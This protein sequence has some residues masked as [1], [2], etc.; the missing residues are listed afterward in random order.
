MTVSR[1]GEVTIPPIRV[2]RVYG[3]DLEASLEQALRGDPPADALQWLCRAVG[4]SRVI[5]VRA[6]PGGMS[7]AVHRVVLETSAGSR[8]AVVLRRYVLDWVVEEAYVPPNEVDVLT[9]LEHSPVPAPRLIAADPDGTVTGT[10]TVV[11]TYLPGRVVWRPDDRE[12]WLRGLVD[13]LLLVHAEPPD[14][15]RDWFPY[16]PSPGQVPPSWT[17]DVPAWERALEA[18]AGPAPSSERVFLHRDYHPG[19]VLWSGLELTGIVDW[20]SAC[21]G[22]PEVD[23]AH[24]RFNLAVNADEPAAAD[25]FLAL[26]QSLT[27]RAEYDPYWDL[28]TAVSVVDD[29]PDPALDAFVSTAAAR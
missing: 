3:H 8:L 22:P 26:W 4:A 18:Y 27:G 21:A 14:G 7:S 9:R 17:R 24:C 28:V 10:P 5:E 29:E 19:N 6:L 25:R 12:A 11:M 13:A 1:S 2:P 23:V 16:A 20:A 15:L